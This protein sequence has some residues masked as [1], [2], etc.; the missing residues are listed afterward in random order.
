M[1]LLF[2][3]IIIDYK[4]KKSVVFVSLYLIKVNMN[5]VRLIFYHQSE[6]IQN[7]N[8]HLWLPKVCDDTN[9]IKYLLYLNMWPHNI[10]H[11][12]NE[13]KNMQKLHHM[14]PPN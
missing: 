2:F 9:N 1:N 14:C 10:K 4:V 13:K 6:A 7:F 8:P 12:M 3:S 5:V 11:L